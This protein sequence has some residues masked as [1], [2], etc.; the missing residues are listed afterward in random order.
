LYLTEFVT[1]H[2]ANPDCSIPLRYLRDGRLFQFEIRS[3]SPHAMYPF[4]ERRRSPR[5][6]SHFWLCGQCS[7]TFTLVFDTLKGVIVK[8]RPAA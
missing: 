2:C 5:S 6:I 4:V 7:S 3:E 1:S 8:P